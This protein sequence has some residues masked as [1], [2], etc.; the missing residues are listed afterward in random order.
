MTR[1]DIDRAVI[2]MR[3]AHD[4]YA[5]DIVLMMQEREEKGGCIKFP[6]KDDCTKVEKDLDCLLDELFSKLY[7][8]ECPF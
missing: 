1:D 7:E 2:K 6:S 3:Q 8:A 5:W 4:A